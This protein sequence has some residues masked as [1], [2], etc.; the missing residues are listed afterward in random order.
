MDISSV[1]GKIDFQLDVGH[2]FWINIDLEWPQRV[3]IT[4]SKI[5]VP[6]AITPLYLY[7]VAKLGYLIYK[8]ARPASFL[9][10]GSEPAAIRWPLFLR[11]RISS[12]RPD[13]PE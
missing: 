11:R 2:G 9:L 12:L 1:S 3:T 6:S 7:I 10:V 4:S 13:S 5:E 8:T